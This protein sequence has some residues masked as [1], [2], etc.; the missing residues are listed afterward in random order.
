MLNGFR[1]YVGTRSKEGVERKTAV[2]VTPKKR[3]LILEFRGDDLQGIR[4]KSVFF[5]KKKKATKPMKYVENGTTSRWMPTDV[6]VG[7]VFYTMA[8]VNHRYWVYGMTALHASM[9]IEEK[10]CQSKVEV[11]V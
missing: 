6:N 7:N 9:E 3:R 1:I 5:F 8:L 4:V 10:K 2:L 11:S